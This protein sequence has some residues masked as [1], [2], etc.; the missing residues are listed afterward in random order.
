M[1]KAWWSD[2]QAVFETHDAIKEGRPDQSDDFS[3]VVITNFS[4]HY[5]GGEP[6]AVVGERIFVKASNP[7]DPLPE[8]DFLA[9][10]EGITRYGGFPRDPELM[11]LP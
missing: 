4:S 2:L 10:W 6:F 7:K 9:V 11:G 1:H 5:F 3:A 8:E